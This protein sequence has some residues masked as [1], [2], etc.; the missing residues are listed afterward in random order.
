MVIKTSTVVTYDI[1]VF[2]NFFSV[3]IKNTESGNIRSFEM[4]DRRNDMPG[5]AKVFLD[6]R[7]YF[8]GFNSMHYDSPVI[9][10]IL[11][12]YKRLIKQTI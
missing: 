10:Y 3:T 4:S 9:S 7:I 12:N 5:I 2:P 1:E 6:P 11:I 8:V